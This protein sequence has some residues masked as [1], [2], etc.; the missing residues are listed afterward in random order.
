[1]I[2]KLLEIAAKAGS[3]AMKY[4]GLS[5]GTIQKQDESPLTLADC[6]SHR[7]IVDLLR[8]AYPEIP[9]LSEESTEEELA[10]RKNWHTFWLV[11][12][13]DGTKEFIKQSGE[14]TVN[15]ALVVGKEPVAGVIHAPVLGKSWSAEKGK[16]AQ[17]HEEKK[18]PNVLRSRQWQA[19]EPVFVASR[20]HAGPQVKS[21]I[22]KYPAAITT[23]MGSSLKFCL[24]AEGKADLYLRDVPTMEWDTAAAQIIVEEAGGLLTDLQGKRLSYN[25]AV[26]RNPALL[27]L[28]DPTFWPELG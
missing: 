3:E 20:D 19:K 7:C 24:V 25:K 1:M 21:L 2:E 14:F 23:S 16:G 18:R 9:V 10:G 28:G 27:T 17:L 12:P 6:A 26:L 4:Y 13:L 11:D 22:E 15:I 5:E 8:E